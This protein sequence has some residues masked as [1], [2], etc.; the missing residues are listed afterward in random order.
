MSTTITFE[1]QT[2]Y[3]EVWSTPLTQLAKKYG[4]SDNG[5]RKVCKAMNIPLPSQGHWAKVAVGRK[6]PKTPLPTTAERTQFTSH[7]HSREPSPA[8]S[9]DNAWLSERIAFE[10]NP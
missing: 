6:M 10:E 8:T 9:G 7:T 5:I 4:L 2:L 3:E 1:R